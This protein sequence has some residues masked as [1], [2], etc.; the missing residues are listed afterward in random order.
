MKK[1]LPFVFLAAALCV[2]EAMGQ[3][4]PSLDWANSIGGSGAV[5]NYSMDTDGSR[6]VYSAGSLIGTAD[7]DPGMGTYNLTSMGSNDIYIS[8]WT[9]SG[10]LSWA[11]SIGGNDDEV[12]YSIHV[13]GRGYLYATGFFSGIVDF[14]PGLGIFN[15]TSSGNVDVFVLKLDSLGNFVW[16]V[17]MGGTDPEIGRSITV[18]DDGNVYTTG[19]YS[20]TADFDPGA[21]VYQLSTSFIPNVFVSK[22]DSNGAFM[23]AAGMGGNSDDEGY[24][25]ALDASNNVYTTGWFTDVADFDP[26]IGVHNLIADGDADAF[27]LKLDAAGNFIWA[28]RIGGISHESARSIGIDATDHILITGSFQDTVDFDPGIGVFELSP[29]FGAETFVLKL[30]AAGNFIWAKSIPATMSGSDRNMALDRAG[31]IYNTGIF[32]GTVDFD[33]GAAVFNLTSAGDWDVFISKLDASGNFIWAGN[34]GG[35][36]PDFGLSIAM[37]D[38]DNLYSSGTYSGTA[39]FDPS[40]NTAYLTS[41]AARD[42]F[43]VKFGQSIALDRLEMAQEPK[44]SLYPNPF[45]DHA[46]LVFEHD[47]Q[48]K[49]TLSMYNIHGQLVKTFPDITSG[50]V[51]IVNA[52]FPAGIYFYQ[53]AAGQQ[54]HASGK[55]LIE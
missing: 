16:A 44:V 20:G 29:A 50:R 36:T 28:N 53:L 22:L 12:A 21:G 17:N 43:V 33:A 32:E 55:M 46:T 11:K 15:L 37:D 35:A 24:A 38:S 3:S 4:L 34:M 40:A 47:L 41:V 2:L 30:N 42:N 51:T 27:V 45:H 23:W 48:A 31:N 7:F 54:I 26:G 1:I 25:I 8:K 9:P 52:H 5:D 39:D 49:Y 13:D 14:D 18:D 6:N 10:N 19:Y